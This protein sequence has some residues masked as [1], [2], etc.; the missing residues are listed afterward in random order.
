MSVEIIEEG[1]E[2]FV[3]MPKEEF[4]RWKATVELAK[5]EKLQKKIE[6]SRKEY[7]QGNSEKWK[8]IRDEI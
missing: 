6:K 5:N 8:E 4:D 2:K 7:E 1:E 3:K